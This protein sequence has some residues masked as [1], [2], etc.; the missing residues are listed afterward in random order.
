MIVE[1]GGW[2]HRHAA[3][4]NDLIVARASFMIRWLS[5]MEGLRLKNEETPQAK[6]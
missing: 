6:D 2:T 5:R 1:S 3:W 4:K